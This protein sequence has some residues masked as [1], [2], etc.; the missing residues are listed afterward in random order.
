MGIK[1]RLVVRWES[2]RALAHLPEPKRT[3]RVA[4]H[5]DGSYEVGKNGSPYVS[6]RL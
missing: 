5:Q 2:P 3:T 4:R 1:E 6:R